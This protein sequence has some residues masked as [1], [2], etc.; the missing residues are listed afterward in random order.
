MSKK[1][2][3]FNFRPVINNLFLFA[4]GDVFLVSGNDFEIKKQFNP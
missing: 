4:P 1:C 3:F 2:D